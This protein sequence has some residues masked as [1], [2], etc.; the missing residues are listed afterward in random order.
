MKKEFRFNNVRYAYQNHNEI[1]FFSIISDW[2]QSSNDNSKKVIPSV[3]K[4]ERNKHSYELFFR[5]R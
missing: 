3:G 5:A 4:N 1:P 2:I